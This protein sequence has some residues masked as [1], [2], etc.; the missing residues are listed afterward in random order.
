MVRRSSQRTA[1]T[2]GFTLVEAEV[3]VADNVDI[4]TIEVLG[5][6]DLQEMEHAKLVG[7]AL[8]QAYP[9]HL[10][11]VFFQGGALVVKNMAMMDGRYGM[12]LD[13]AQRY[14]ASALKHHAIMSAGELLERCGVK[15]GRWNGM[16]FEKQD[17]T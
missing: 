5:N 10:W 2:K 3:V 9:D 13:N 16:A 6:E 15:R 17:R 4:A 1:R 14:S 11:A 7:E 12:I 8:Q